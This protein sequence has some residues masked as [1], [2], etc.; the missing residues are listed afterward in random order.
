MFTKGFEKKAG[1]AGSWGLNQR[2][3]AD[4]SRG[5][6]QGGSMPSMGQMWQNMKDAFRPVEAPKAPQGAPRNVGLMSSN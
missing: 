3:A 4:F 2:A 5:A 1:T 6:R